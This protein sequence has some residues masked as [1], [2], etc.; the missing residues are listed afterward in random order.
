[1]PGRWV[2][3]VVAARRFPP[4]LF[5]HLQRSVCF[6]RFAEWHLRGSGCSGVSQNCNQHAVF[7]GVVVVF[8]NWCWRQGVHGVL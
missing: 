2:A 3:A 6:T 8:F 7:L 5:L 4:V 1:M